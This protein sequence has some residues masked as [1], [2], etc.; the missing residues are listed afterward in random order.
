MAFHIIIE[1]I[2]EKDTVANYRFKSDGG[3][4]GVFQ[5]NKAS[6]EVRILEEMPGDK[7]GHI[8]NRAAVKIMREWKQ[9]KLPS[10]TEWAS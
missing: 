3:L 2:D 6:G 7:A 9:G 8:F 10:V 5:I 1:M 4:T